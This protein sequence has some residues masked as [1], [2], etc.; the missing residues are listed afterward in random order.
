MFKAAGKII[1]ALAA[2]VIL[3]GGAWGDDRAEA[4]I[5][6][7]LVKN[8]PW[9]GG[10]L[11]VE[12]IQVPGLDSE[13]YDSMSLELPRGI[14]NTGKVSFKA[15][16]YSKGKEKD[17]WGSAK[18]KVYNDAVVALKSIK[19]NKPI[20]S[21]DVKLVKVDM[22][23]AGEALVSLEEAAG[24]LAKRPIPAGSI[25]KREY[26]KPEVIVKRGERVTLNVQ[27]P[28]ISIR[29]KGTASEDGHKGGVIAVRTAS[30]K[31]ITGRV[32]GP[33]EII[34]EF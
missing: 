17:L 14:R 20:N 30:G 11:R 31:Q 16:L 29:S 2:V 6:A 33:G 22:A 4:F 23:E 25:I 26:V 32:T 10:D 19:A 5:K 3:S 8:S 24:M 13:K 34:I 15:V 21:G 7:E 9:E 1:T 18:L 27:G 12:D 28:K